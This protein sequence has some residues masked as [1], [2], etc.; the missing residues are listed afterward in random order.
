MRA[1]RP[2]V[3]KFFLPVMLFAG[4]TWAL[5]FVF[6]FTA[7]PRHGIGLAVL[8]AFGGIVMAA[9]WIVMALGVLQRMRAGNAAAEKK[10]DDE[11]DRRIGT[12]EI[13]HVRS[14]DRP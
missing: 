14:G 8:L 13:D 2:V 3:R 6:S 4:L 9:P 7:L 11:D 1:I 10:D 12:N 5:I